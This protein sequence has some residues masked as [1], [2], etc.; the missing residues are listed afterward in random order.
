[1]GYKKQPEVAAQSVEEWVAGGG[2]AE[3]YGNTDV[4]TDGNTDMDTDG[5]TEM[6]TDGNSDRNSDANAREKK[7]GAKNVAEGAVRLKMID[8]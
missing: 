8:E 5:N 6:N 7:E 4:D 1:M 3:G 2:K